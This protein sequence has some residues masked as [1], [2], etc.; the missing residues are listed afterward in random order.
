MKKSATKLR[1]EETGEIRENSITTMPCPFA[2]ISWDHWS[3]QR[4]R[5]SHTGCHTTSKESHT[6]CHTTSKD[7]NTSI[8]RAVLSCDGL[9]AAVGCWQV[10]VV[11]AGAGGGI[12]GS[13]VVVWGEG[14]NG[15]HS[16]LSACLSSVL[17]NPAISR[18]LDCGVYRPARVETESL[19]CSWTEISNVCVCD[20]VKMFSTYFCSQKFDFVNRYKIRY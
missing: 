8:T 4:V 11:A 16:P 19:V 7:T 12:W 6:A 10:Y 18:C 13:V 15:M 1:D 17:G 2:I 5:Q 9:K 14:W 3:H 20:Y